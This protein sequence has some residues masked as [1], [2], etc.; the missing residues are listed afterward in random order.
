MSGNVISTPDLD[1]LAEGLRTLLGQNLAVV[2]R[3]KNPY[4]STFPT[5]IVTCAVNGTEQKVF[6][7]YG[8]GDY[9]SDWGIRAGVPYETAVHHHLLRKVGLPVPAYWGGYVDRTG[10]HWLALE[11]LDDALRANKAG[12]D[13]LV[14]A[15]RWIGSFHRQCDRL[16][17]ADAMPFIVYDDAFYRSRA[18]RALAQLSS[19]NSLL[20]DRPLISKIIGI[21]GDIIAVLLESPTVIHGE[22]Y[23]RNILVRGDTVFPI[24]WEGAAFA[25]GEIDLACLTDNWGEEI[26]AYCVDGYVQCRWPMGAPADFERRLEAARLFL[27]LRWLGT[28]W[29]WAT[30][31]KASWI[32]QLCD[33]LELSATKMGLI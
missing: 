22:Y 21:F 24:D 5:E 18:D 1:T 15:A 33:Q 16:H 7:K 6:C 28:G 30:P 23:G 25:A 32:P 8:P 27:C 31:A 17:L 20:E 26:T 11:C 3:S 10:R 14:K 19:Q 9:E 12:E 29:V 4:T 13:G 2:E